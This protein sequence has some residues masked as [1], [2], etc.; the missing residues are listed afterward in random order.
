LAGILSDNCTMP[1]GRR[2]PFLIACIPAAVFYALLFNPPQACTASSS[3][4]TQAWVL[5]FGLA[6]FSCMAIPYRLSFE[7]VC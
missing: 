4:A 7:L 2:R 6:F 3:G 1:L 5:S